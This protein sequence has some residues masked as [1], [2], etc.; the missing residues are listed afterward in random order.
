MKIY[1]YN[2]FINFSGAHFLSGLCAVCLLCL[3]LASKH[4]P[5]PPHS[6]SGKCLLLVPM[7][8]LPSLLCAPNLP[9]QGTHTKQQLPAI[10]VCPP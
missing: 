9:Q 8:S 3:E 4:F 10:H 2:S 5:S 1:T 7:T 6:P